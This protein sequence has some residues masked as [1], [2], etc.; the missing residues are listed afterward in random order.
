MRTPPTGTPRNSLEEC[1][2][3]EKAWLVL[4]DHVS[5][6]GT[7][8]RYTR[9]PDA[10]GQRRARCQATTTSRGPARGIRWCDA[11]M[12]LAFRKT[13]VAT[14]ASRSLREC[15]GRSARVVR[16]RGVVDPFR[17]TVLAQLGRQRGSAG[18]FRRLPLTVSRW[19]DSP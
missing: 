10:I 7:D 3:R 16:T 6:G 1:N 15:S 11:V 5:N 4:L 19:P 12:A 14:T 18:R 8:A 2:P 17:V 9:R 13:Y